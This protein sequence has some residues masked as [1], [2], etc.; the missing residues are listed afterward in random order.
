MLIM[1]EAEMIWEGEKSFS[2]QSFASPY[3]GFIQIRFNG[4]HLRLIGPPLCKQ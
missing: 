1:R 4:Y 3:A 2:R